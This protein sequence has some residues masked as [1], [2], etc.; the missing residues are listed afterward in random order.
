MNQ[1]ESISTLSLGRGNGPERLVGVRRGGVWQAPM[2][3]ISHESSSLV[4]QP[5]G[6]AADP[7]LLRSPSQAYLGHHCRPLSLASGAGGRHA[8][9]TWKPTSSCLGRCPLRPRPPPTALCASPPPGAALLRKLTSSQGSGP[10]V[11]PSPQSSDPAKKHPEYPG[12]PK[13]RCLTW[14][15]SVQSLSRVRLSATPWTWST[16]GPS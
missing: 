5:G 2:R 4:T 15:S 7:W 13:A 6:L 1:A 3:L 10:Q 11:S 16:P 14:V 8:P 12:L 9:Q